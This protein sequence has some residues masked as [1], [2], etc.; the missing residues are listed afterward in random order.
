MRGEAI[1]SREV[2]APQVAAPRR[3]STDTVRYVVEELLVPTNSGK[4]LGREFVFHLEVVGEGIGI[5]ETGNLETGL[6][7]FRPHL[8][9]V[10]GEGDVLAEH[11]LV[12]I[13][14]VAAE[15]Q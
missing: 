3:G 6:E 14:D 12:V 2:R 9:V 13:A 1:S 4:K 5:G 11:A 7:K 10:P 15:G 8:P